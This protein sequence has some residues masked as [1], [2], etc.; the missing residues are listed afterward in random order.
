MKIFISLLI[1]TSALVAVA[2]SPVGSSGGAI[3]TPTPTPSPQVTPSPGGPITGPTPTP[4]SRPGSLCSVIDLADI[5]ENDHACASG[6]WTATKSGSR[7][8]FCCEPQS[9][10]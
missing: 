5:A 7:V 2:N 4:A 8:R 6:V 1:C 9:E 10:Y 3:V